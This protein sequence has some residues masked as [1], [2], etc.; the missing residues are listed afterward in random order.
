MAKRFIAYALLVAVLS[1][2]AI[3]G[4]FYAQGTGGDKHEADFDREIDPLIARQM[5]QAKS[6]SFGRRQTFRASRE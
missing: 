6:T 4:I 5:H 2:I 3:T 1:S